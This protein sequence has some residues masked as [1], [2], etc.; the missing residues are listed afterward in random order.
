MVRKWASGLLV[1]FCVGGLLVATPLAQWSS[2]NGFPFSAAVGLNRGSAP[3]STTDL[4]YNVAGALYFNGSAVGGTGAPTDAT[5]ITQ[6][7]DGTL[8]AEQ[9]LATLASGLLLNATKTGVLSIAAANTDYV[10]PTGITN[11]TFANA[12]TL[13][14]GTTAADTLLLQAYDTDTG[15]GYLPMAT[16]AGGTAPSWSFEDEIFYRERATPT[17]KFSVF[18]VVGATGLPA[19]SATITL[20]NNQYFGVTNYDRTQVILTVD[21]NATAITVAN[22]TSFDPILIDPITKG[23]NAFIGTITSLDLTAA[24]TW[25]FP[26]LTGTLALMGGVQNGSTFDATGFL[27]AGVA[28]IDKTCGGP[29]ISAT[30]VK[31]ILTA[32]TCTSEP[33][34]DPHEAGTARLP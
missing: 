22:T 30:F 17:N 31:G 2:I 23:A 8:S 19:H 21:P 20:Y 11:M 13:R 1:G 3:S 24:Q 34:P 26:D 15:P 7:A 6:T 16:I 10:A 18:Q 27:V 4:L 33:Q 14:T 9:A 25:T 32:M 12:G 5:Y 28:G 29:V